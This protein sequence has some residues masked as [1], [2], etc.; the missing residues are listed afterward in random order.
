MARRN[1]YLILFE[2]RYQHHHESPNTWCIIRT[3]CF[4]QWHPLALQFHTGVTSPSPTVWPD[5]CQIRLLIWNIRVLM[6]FYDNPYPVT[7][8]RNFKKIKVACLNFTIDY[9]S[10]LYIYSNLNKKYPHN[11]IYCIQIHL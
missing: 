1:I 2:Y 7:T 11:T 8:E 3:Q 4:Q 9:Q 5:P 6:R 10:H